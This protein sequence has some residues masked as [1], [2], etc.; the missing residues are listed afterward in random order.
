MMQRIGMVAARDFMAVVSRKAF[1]IGLLLMPMLI[2]LFVVVVPRLLGSYG[3]H[4]IGQIELIDPTGE[5][6]MHLEAALEP[7]AI[8][9]HRARANASA[10]VP[11]PI[12]P[13]SSPAHPG[14]LS[15]A[16][17]QLTV[18]ERPSSSP[19]PQAERW[20][21]EPAG[22][23]RPGSSRLALVVVQPDAV[24]RAPGHTDF[25][26]Y[27]LFLGPHVNEA[28]ESA[29][30]EA[31]SEALIAARFQRGAIDR[32]A[33]ETAMQVAVPTVTVVTRAGPHAEQLKF[34]RLLPFACGILLFIGIITGGQTLMT[35]TVEEKSSRVIEVLLA[36]VSPI[37]LMT[38]K[39]LGQLGVG[40]VTMAVYLGLGILAMKEYAAAGLI[41]PM[42]I[43]Y[44]VVFYLLA[45]LVYGGLMLAI[46]SA[47]N[48][49]A[50]AQSLM[51][52]VMLLL[53][54]PYIL[55]PFIGMAPN[56]PL[57]VTMSFVPPV[58]SFVILARLASATP[59][60]LWQVLGAIAAGLAGAVAVIWFAAKV[61]RIGLLMHGKPPNFATLIRWARAA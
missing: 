35:S 36:A 54:A 50:E 26:S 18:V 48:Q 42:L 40:L 27:E 56:S 33:V 47:V 37:E 7:A 51:G 4:V 43:V 11:R 46:G 22:T 17:P 2:L 39:L 19:L 30:R 15:A 16:I 5:V 6:S 31:M 61:F 21:L 24:V 1:L 41:A 34:T 57:S 45:Y 3:Q 13:Q 38:G 9:A 49:I 44:L 12:A 10:E 8:A 29:I 60:P 55:V 53:V 59:P 23:G 20:L 25:G 52:P 28:T 14:P 58:N 32:E